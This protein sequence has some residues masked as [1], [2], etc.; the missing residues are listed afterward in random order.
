MKGRKP[1][2]VYLSRQAMDIFVALPCAAGSCGARIRT[3]CHCTD[4]LVHARR[5]PGRMGA[6]AMLP[7]GEQKVA[8]G[9]QGEQARDEC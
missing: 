9:S 2:V 5:K 4:P 8:N 7:A 3:A 1:H 6:C